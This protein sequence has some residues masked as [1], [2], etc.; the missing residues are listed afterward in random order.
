MDRG[1]EGG[2]E[3]S[4]ENVNTFCNYF[5]DCLLIGSMIKSKY[6]SRVKDMFNGNFQGLPFDGAIHC[7]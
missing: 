5:V 3:G 4:E 7:F 1:G 2:G 6:C